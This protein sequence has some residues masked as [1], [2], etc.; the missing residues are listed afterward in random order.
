VLEV[1]GRIVWMKGVELEPEPG[2]EV[3]ASSLDVPETGGDG[4]ARQK[5]SMELWSMVP[6]RNGLGGLA[7]GLFQF[8]RLGSTIKLLLIQAAGYCV[9]RKVLCT[10]CDLR[11]AA[12]V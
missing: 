12:S 6:S 3:V 8:S 9:C 11:E 5:G 7:V 10:F 4:G 1:S 2:I